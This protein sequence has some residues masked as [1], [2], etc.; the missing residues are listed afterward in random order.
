MYTTEVTGA[1]YSEYYHRY[2]FSRYVPV[3]YPVP[4]LYEND[5]KQQKPVANLKIKV[6]LVLSSL[7]YIVHWPPYGLPY[8]S[9]FSQSPRTNRIG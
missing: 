8:L 6:V 2:S 4:C 7:P 1:R 5:G 3:L 9:T